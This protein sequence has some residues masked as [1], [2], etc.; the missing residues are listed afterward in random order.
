MKTQPDFALESAHSGVVC[1]IDEAGRGPWAGPV[2]AAAVIWPEGASIPAGLNDSKK[3]SETK[4]EALFEQIIKRAHYGIGEASVEEIDGSNILAA[5]KLAMQ[6]AFEALPHRPDVALI[7][8]NQPPQLPCT[9]EAVVKGDSQSLS[10]AAAS[11]IAKVT[12]DLLMK[13]IG[14][15]YPEYGFEKHAGYGTKQHQSAL[16]VH[17][18]TEHHRR[19]FRPVRELLEAS[20]S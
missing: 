12:R 10:I 5:T 14:A 15:E 9:V 18:V 4:R 13:Q 8:G 7:D 3:L 19:S 11:I 6:R 17:G 2:T 1:G 16:A 20:A